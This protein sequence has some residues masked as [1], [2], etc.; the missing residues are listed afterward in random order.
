[1]RVKKTKV[2]KLI[3]EINK[4]IEKA[5]QFEKK[6]SKNLTKLDKK[7]FQSGRNLIHYLAL[8]SN[9]IRDL[10]DKLGDLGVS[11]LGKAEAHVM[12][13]LLKV[14]HILKSLK[15]DKRVKPVKDEISRKESRKLLAK[16]SDSLL[17]KI[18]KGEVSR[19]M[20]TLPSEAADDYNLVLSLID[21]GMNIARIN[22][23]HDTKEQ[24]AKMIS[25]IHTAEKELKKRCLIS[26]DLGGPKLRTG[27]M[28]PGP[29]VLHIQPE[30]DILGNLVKPAKVIIT[31]EIPKNPEENTYYFPVSQEA[32]NT[33]SGKSEILLTD[34]RGKESKIK[35]AEKVSSGFVGYCKD[36]IYLLTGTEI[37][38]RTDGEI[39][40]KFRIDEIPP[41]EEKILLKVGDI[42]NLH[43]NNDFGEPASYNENG[44][45][46]KP[47]HI[48]CTLP[49]V[50]ENIRKGEIVLLDDGAIEGVIESVSEEEIVIKITYAKGETAKLKGDKGINLPDSNLKISGLTE[51]D[52]EDI[53]FIVLNANIVNLSFVNTKSDVKE[54]LKYLR[55]IKAEK[56]GIVLKIETKKGFDN[57]PS[58]LLTAMRH[59]P[60]GVMIARGD[61]A[62]ECGWKNLAEI[63]DEIMLLCE[64]AHIPVIWA[65]QVLETSAKKGRPS[66]AEITDASM[67]QRAECVM[68]NKGPHI[69]R[70]ISLLKEIIS[71]QN[72]YFTKQAPLLPK[73]KVSE[74]EEEFN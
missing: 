73:I 19:I 59:Y 71:K 52:K 17:G 48:S 24:W 41:Y 29:K 66:R 39:G 2:T 57:L 7:Y 56:I 31:T 37:L 46:I 11:R 53:K 51:K 67:S 27:A 40:S 3:E 47:A 25:H 35:V 5:E 23:A 12:F 15:N 54:L 45:L 69:I 61:L 34:T 44:E 58:I 1:M 50:F 4:I 9:D 72:E 68:L 6:F 36:T 30:R 60:I 43:K 33:M 26:M 70:T 63:Q 32:I 22:C 21:A 16:H 13:S 74:P 64:A 14:E 18:S 49:E 55:D 38:I 10:Q 62:I 65:T 8:R 42:L 28:K 20:V